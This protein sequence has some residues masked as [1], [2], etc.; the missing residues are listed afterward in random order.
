MRQFIL[1]IG[2][3]VA[4]LIS[5]WELYQGIASI[6]RSELS[7]SFYHIFVTLPIMSSVAICFDHV[8]SQMHEDYR[9]F[10]RSIAR[11]KGTQMDI[12]SSSST[13]VNNTPWEDD[14]S[15]TH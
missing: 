3:L 8:N 10:R 9:K 5:C 11:K 13:E 6:I 14:S 12:Y 4:V 7:E 2:T 1:T 15:H